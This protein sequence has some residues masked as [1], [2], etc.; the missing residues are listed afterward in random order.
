MRRYL[1]REVETIANTDTFNMVYA[2][3]TD[4]LDLE[5]W[6]FLVNLGWAGKA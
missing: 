6:C 4:E 5:I 2:E 3:A 1:E